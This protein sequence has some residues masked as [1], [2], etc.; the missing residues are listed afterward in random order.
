[1]LFLAS[2]YILF[3]EIAQLILTKF[4]SI[5]ELYP[6][7]KSFLVS[8]SSFLFFFFVFYNKK[9]KGISLIALKPTIRI[10]DFK[11]RLYILRPRRMIY[12]SYSF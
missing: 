2:F 7:R 8:F 11:I 3:T 4:T 10:K 5:H 12:L 1:M 6:K 9:R